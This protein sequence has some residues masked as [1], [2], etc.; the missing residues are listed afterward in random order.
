MTESGWKG[1]PR[2]REGVWLREAAGENILYQRA[3]R[4]VH[5]LNGTALAIWELCDGETLPEEMVRAICELFRLQPER[6]SDD[7]LRTLQD[8]ERA[9]LIEWVT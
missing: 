7:L 8:F 6:V 4:A 1:R 3:T 2:K 9:E 5:L